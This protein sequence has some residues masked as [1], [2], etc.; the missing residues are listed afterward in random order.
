MLSCLDYRDRSERIVYLFL[1]S[2]GVLEGMESRMHLNMRPQ[3]RH[4][5]RLGLEEAIRNS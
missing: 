2:K 1:C 4:I 3:I 5:L